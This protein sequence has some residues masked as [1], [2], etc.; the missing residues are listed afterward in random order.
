MPLILWSPELLHVDAVFDVERGGEFG[1]HPNHVPTTLQIYEDHDAGYGE[2]GVRETGSFDV[3]WE[4]LPRLQAFCAAVTAK[5]DAVM[6]GTTS[7]RRL[8]RRRALRLKR[9]A[10]HLLQAYQR[11]HSDYGV[12]EQETDELHLDY[13]IAPARSVARAMRS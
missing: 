6:D 7:S 13:V 4:Q 3:T 9:A 2:V 1:L 10:R 5:I 11:T 12:W 8:P